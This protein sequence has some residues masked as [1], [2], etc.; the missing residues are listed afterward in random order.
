MARPAETPLEDASRQRH[1]SENFG[2]LEYFGTVLCFQRF[3]LGFLVQYTRFISFLW[4]ILVCLVR[5][6]FLL[7]TLVLPRKSIVFCR[8]AWF[9]LYCTKKPKW[10]CWKHRTVPKYPKNPNF[11]Q[12]WR[13]RQRLRSRMPAGYAMVA[14]NLGFLGIL[15]QFYVFTTFIW[16]FWYSTSVLLFFC[17]KILFCLTKSGFSIEN[18]SF[19]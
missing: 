14:K 12:L 7:K 10:N 4:K 15:V 16:V 5:S 1:S 3:H 19:A 8:K 2:F 18:I 13:G 9:C 11:S 6:V 17:D